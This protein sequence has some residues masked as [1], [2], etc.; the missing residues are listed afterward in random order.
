MAI[1][2]GVLTLPM[3]HYVD[4]NA[5]IGAAA[6]EVDRVG[7]ALSDYVEELG[8][9]FK[10]LKSRRAAC[11]QL[12]LG[13]WWDSVERTRT[14]E[15][16]KLQSYL[17]Y[18]RV[19]ASR[20]LICLSELQTLIGRAFRAAMTMPRG[21]RVYLSELLRLTRGLRLP[22]HRRRMTSLARRDV[23]SLI[24]L[25]ESNHGK[26][27][28]DTSHLPWAPAV[29]TDAM[30]SGRRAG[31]GW[32]DETDRHDAGLYGSSMRHKPIDELEGDAVRRAVDSLGPS[33]RNHRVPIFID[34]SSFQ[35]S[36][37]KGWSRARRLNGILRDLAAAS[38]RY[39]CVLIPIWLSTHDNGGADALSRGDHAEYCRWLRSHAP[40][41]FARSDV[42][43]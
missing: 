28:F 8:V 4:D 18:F 41:V 13:F 3:P 5:L 15:E 12:A 38:L 32:C 11:L 25:L 23:R 31:W 40:R 27:Y 22:W 6:D 26:G 7:E 17:A 33:W 21:S 20:R 19:I 2:D 35:R 24:D 42:R 34:N 36:M 9:S 1:A 43:A 10:R 14:L 16:G 30:K 37:H 39:D 29:Y